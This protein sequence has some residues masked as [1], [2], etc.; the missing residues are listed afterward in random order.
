VQASIM[1]KYY[2]LVEM[3]NRELSQKLY[4]LSNLAKRKH[5]VVAGHY[6]KAVELILECKTELKWFNDTSLKILFKGLSKSTTEVVKAILKG[7]PMEKILR[8]K[9]P[10]YEKKYDEK[11]LDY[12]YQQKDKAK[13]EE[14]RMKNDADGL[15]GTWDNII[16]IYEG[17]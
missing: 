16:R 3:D 9:V 4:E 14:E 8:Q 5:P 6:R 17:D 11:E 10:L 1:P 7:E 13:L 12:L 15:D 2:F